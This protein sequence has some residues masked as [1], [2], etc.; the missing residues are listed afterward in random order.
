MSRPGIAHQPALDGLRAVSVLVV[1][2]FHGQITGFTGGYLGVSVFFTLSGYL[3][4]SLLIAERSGT[5][6]TGVGA[7]YV[8][9]A[10]RLLPASLLCL[11]AIAVAAAVTDW[12]DAVTTLRRDLLGALFQVSNWVSLSGSGSY[13]QLFSASCGSVVARRALLVA[14]HRGAV[15]LAVAA[16]V[17]R[18]VS[19]GAHACRPYVDHRCRDS[20]I[21]A[22]RTGDHDRVGRRRRR[23][24]PPR[25]EPPRSSPV[26]SSRS[27]CGVARHRAGG[28][29]SQSS[30]SACS[31][32]RWSPSPQRVGPRTTARSPW[33]AWSAPCWWPACRRPGC[34]ARRWAHARWCGSGRSA[35]AS[36]C[37]TGRSSSCSTS[38][39]ST[40]RSPSLFAVRMAITLVIA[41]LSFV[42]PR[43]SDPARHRVAAA[44]DR[45]CS[46]RGLRGGR[47]GGRGARARW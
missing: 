12:F 47:R 39:A 16:G 41:Q 23:T 44:G 27:C 10:K 15:L 29:R 2:L 43:A 38:N 45:R 34:C 8:R 20:R 25:R 13:Q 22:A 42:A 46:A 21:R 11:T 18:A 36:T 32:S 26:R 30:P 37:S 17:R 33:S 6:D 35:T 1:L 7:F 19:G 4:T 5:G 9:R 28:A 31:R 3:I 14:G 24:G 40:S